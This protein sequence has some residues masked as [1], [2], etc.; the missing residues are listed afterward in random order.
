VEGLQGVQGQHLGQALQ[1]AGS[2]KQ[3]DVMH[4]SSEQ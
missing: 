4:S 1:G 3:A 2:S